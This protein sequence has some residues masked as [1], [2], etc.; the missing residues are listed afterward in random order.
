[1]KSKRAVI[2]A[3]GF[4]EWHKLG[5]S[6]RPYFVHDANAE[7]IYFAGLYSWWRDPAAESD[8]AWVL[9]ATILTRAG[10]GPIE[11][12]H[13][14]M[15]ITLAATDLVEWL[16]QETVGDQSLLDEF[17]ARGLENSERLSTREVGLEVGN[18]RNNGPALIEAVV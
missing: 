8:K 15:P 2:P 16:D 7:L 9:S 1:M 11:W 12:L 4:Y 3:N 6:K 18:V 5:D 10:G 13:D 14:R 17:A